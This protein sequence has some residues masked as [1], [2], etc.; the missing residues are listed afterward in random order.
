[1][2]T[3]PEFHRW[4]SK[5]SAENVPAKCYRFLFL[6]IN[7]KES[8]WFFIK[9][10]S[11]RSSRNS[12]RVSIEKGNLSSLR[13]RTSCAWITLRQAQDDQ[14]NGRTIISWR[15]RKAFPAWGKEQAWLTHPSK[16]SG[17]THLTPKALP[18]FNCLTICSCSTLPKLWANKPLGHVELV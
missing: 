1:M 7:G 11:I 5:H 15:K 12:E 9:P 16:G 13:K 2:S 14:L 17:G 6:F 18:P 8:Y 10:G 3:K 4:F